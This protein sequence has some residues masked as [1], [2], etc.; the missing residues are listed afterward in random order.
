MY[1]KNI[2][3]KLIKSGEA[4]ANLLLVSAENPQEIKTGQDRQR[5]W[6]GIECLFYQVQRKN[7]LRLIIDVL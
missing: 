7:P 6:F 1:Q 4:P 3:A 5:R 2:P